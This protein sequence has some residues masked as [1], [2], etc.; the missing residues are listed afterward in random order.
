MAGLDAN[1]RKVRYILYGMNIL[2]VSHAFAPAIGGAETLVR[3]VGTDL[4]GRGN[5]VTVITSDL[6]S[7]EGF[8]E[9]GVAPVGVTEEF[10]EGVLVRRI[11]L[12]PRIR[13]RN[14]RDWTQTRFSRALRALTEDHDF[15]VVMALPHL[16]P[17]V[18][19]AVDLSA[20]R[21]TPLVLTPLLHENDPNW[22]TED[23]RRVLGG[24][25]AVIAMTRHEADRLISGYGVDG[26]RVFVSG[27]GV[28]ATVAPQTHRPSPMILY[29]GRLAPSKNL[30]L[31][32]EAFN[33]LTSQSTDAELVIAGGSVPGVEPVQ[34]MVHRLAGMNSHRIRVFSDIDEQTKTSLL[35]NARCLVSPSINESFGL[36][37]LEAMAAGTP[38]IAID[39]P[40]NREIVFPDTGI[41]VANEPEALSKAMRTLI[42]HDRLAADF[43]AAANR[44]ASEYYSWNKVGETYAAAYAYAQTNHHRSEPR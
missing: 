43:G 1:Q 8:F 23:L 2:H 42:D 15:D 33:R 5:Q 13:R 12:S 44:R 16:L 30:G 10:D 31:L 19:A 40:I 17:N 9:P 34:D 21:D 3:R 27:L 29:L 32:I 18:I 38:V 4:V 26:D 37:L 36:V 7:A 35:A 24:V 14:H 20:Q 11:P 22:P 6:M 25:D 39:R 41:L 28:E